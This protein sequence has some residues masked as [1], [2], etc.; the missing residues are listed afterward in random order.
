[1]NEIYDCHK[2]LNI[3]IET[4]WKMTVRDRRFMIARHNKDAQ[5]ERMSEDGSKTTTAID[6]FTDLE[7]AN[8]KNRSMH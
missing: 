2:Y 1:M 6:R 3:P 4:L 8:Q 7:I 5:E